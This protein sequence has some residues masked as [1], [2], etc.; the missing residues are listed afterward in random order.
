VSI[1]STKPTYKIG[2]IELSHWHSWEYLEGVKKTNFAKVV[3]VSDKKK[4]ISQ[5]IAARYKCN[6]YTNYK[7]LL[8]KESLDFVFILGQ[9]VE[10]P[11]ITNYVVEK[12]IPF[13]VEKP[14]AINS[15]LLVPIIRKLEKLRIFNS[16]AFPYRTSPFVELLLRW[17]KEK[18]LGEWISLKFKYITGSLERYRKWGCEWMLDKKK[19]GGGCTINLAVHYI[20]LFRYLTGENIVDVKSFLS[21]KKHKEEVEDYSLLL[22]K[23]NKGTL[24]E[25]ETG[26]ISDDPFEKDNIIIYTRRRRI[27]LIRN[28]VIWQDNNKGRM[29]EELLPNINLR[30]LFVRNLLKS[31]NENKKPVATLK[32]GYE[33]LK[34]IDKVYKINE[35]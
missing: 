16:V 29:G 21:N 17:K 3:A 32:D 13:C 12:K 14:C 34:V 23:S 11:E 6:Y 4:E 19:S 15:A 26:Y 24:C 2:F 25:I 27:E 30:E 9:H 22:L 10:M 5:Q 7:E 35:E 18:I 20:D 8:E 1:I 31:L 33:S 28:K